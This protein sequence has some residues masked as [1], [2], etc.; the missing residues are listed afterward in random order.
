[1]HRQPPDSGGCRHLFQAAADGFELKVLV[2]QGITVAELDFVAAQ[3]VIGGDAELE[4]LAVAPT[5]VDRAL[6]MTADVDV[7]VVMTRD[8]VENPYQVEIC[9]RAIAATRPGTRVIHVALRGPYDRGTLGQVDTTVCTFGD[10]AVSL[11]A[12]PGILSGERPIT[13]TMPVRLA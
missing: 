11:R 4:M 12:L 6:A 13:A 8:A 7:L 9:S 10:P 5:G 3:A 2:V 1:M